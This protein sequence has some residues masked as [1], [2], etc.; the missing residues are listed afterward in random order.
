MGQ[1]LCVE[2]SAVQF[3]APISTAGL[4]QFYDPA[5]AKTISLSPDQFRGDFKAIHFPK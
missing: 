3:V 5:K 4:H 1:A 2:L